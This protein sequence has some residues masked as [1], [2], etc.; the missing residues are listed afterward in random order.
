[1][2]KNAIQN[3]RCD[4]LP[5]PCVCA[6]LIEAP[7]W[8]RH[9]CNILFHFAIILCCQWK[10]WISFL[11]ARY[12]STGWDCWTRCSIANTCRSCEPWTWSLLI[13]GALSS[14]IARPH[15]Q[16]HHRGLSFV[17]DRNAQRRILL[18]PEWIYDDTSSAVERICINW[19]RNLFKS[20]NQ[21]ARVWETAVWMDLTA[22][23]L[24]L[25]SLPEWEHSRKPCSPR[26]QK[27]QKTW[28]TMTALRN[29]NFA[30]S[31]LMRV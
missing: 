19:A 21:K 13:A 29:L 4:L 24:L 8:Y 7:I 6:S 9:C 27:L 25:L 11:S 26:N 5:L 3:Y 2:Q 10:N 18:D 16:A 12:E 15:L 20:N 31:T 14:L 28:T 23:W 17:L 30:N 22:L 1:M